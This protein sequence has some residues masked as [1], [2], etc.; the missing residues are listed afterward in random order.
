[1]DLKQCKIKD[2]D[3]I[4]YATKESQG[5]DNAEDAIKYVLFDD[6]TVFSKDANKT[7]NKYL[8]ISNSNGARKKAMMMQQDDLAHIMVKYCMQSFGLREKDFNIVDDE[9]LLNQKR[10]DR[11]EISPYEM[12]EQ[13]AYLAMGDVY[14][15]YDYLFANKKI[16]SSVVSYMMQERYI[17]ELKDVL[18]NFS[19]IV[20]NN[21]ISTETR[22]AFYDAYVKIDDSFAEIKKNNPDYIK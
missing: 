11:L 2:F 9:L 12:I 19:G 15:A 22:Y 13:V 18:D 20:N 21:D 6:E 1:M 7:D 14:V 4:F 16:L 17:S 8:Y 5:Y 3:D 10:I